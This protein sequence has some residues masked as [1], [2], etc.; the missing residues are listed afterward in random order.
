[1]EDKENVK[2]ILDEKVA[3]L[4]LYWGEC[5]KELVLKAHK[6]GVK[7]VPQVSFQHNYFTFSKIHYLSL[8]SLASLT[9]RIT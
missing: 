3:V 6:A 2:A 5:S 7:V 4:Q 8:E 9:C 1:M